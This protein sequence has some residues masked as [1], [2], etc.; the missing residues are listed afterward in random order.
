M[1]RTISRSGRYFAGL[2]VLLLA[3][4]AGGPAGAQGRGGSIFGTPPPDPM[5]EQVIKK[6]RLDQKLDAQV[7]LDTPFVD[8][9]GR[10][11]KL[12]D[13]L[14]DKPAL[15]MLIQ[16]RCR[17]LCTEEMNVL[18]TSLRE[19]KFDVGKQFNLVIVSIDPRETPEL[20]A[21]KKKAYVDAYGRPRTADG[22][23]FLT[24]NQRDIDRLAA[25]IGYHYTFDPRTD[26]YA[27]PDGVIVL[28]P[29]GKV[30]R[31]FFRL[32]YPAQGLRLGLVE[33]ASNRI[34]T[35]LDALALLCYHYDPQ[36]GSYSLAFMKVLRLGGL[37]TIMLMVTGL[38]TL[39]LRDRQHR[40]ETPP[41]GPEGQA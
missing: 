36:T 41:A 30:A 32:H 4:G 24:G 18:L 37:L 21:A 19:M 28:T 33:A 11:V 6:V 34:G 1:I 25:S 22:W 8:D 2:A 3:I 9:H 5:P 29:Q 15:L 14:G 7:P 10:S 39:K 12:G 16:Y 38:A 13:V 40:R 23:H 31:Y 20:A 35:P 27:H 26:Q 17:M